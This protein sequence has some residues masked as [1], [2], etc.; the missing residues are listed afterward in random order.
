MELPRLSE[1]RGGGLSGPRRG[2]SLALARSSVPLS[3]EVSFPSRS[4]W[5]GHWRW[6]VNTSS[7]SLIH[8]LTTPLRSL[9]GW[10]LSTTGSTGPSPT[11]SRSG[12][13]RPSRTTRCSWTSGTSKT[14]ARA[15]ACPGPMPGCPAP[16]TPR[17]V[18]E[19][20][21]SPSST[22][23]CRRHTRIFRSS[24]TRVRFQATGSMTTAM[25]MSTTLT[26]GI[27][28]MGDFNPNPDLSKPSHGTAVAGVTGAT[29]NNALGVTGACQNCQILSARIFDGNG[30]IAPDSAVAEAINYAGNMADVLNNS[31]GGGSPSTAIT[32]AIQGANSGGRGGLGSP[33][34]CSNANS[35]SGYRSYTLLGVPAGT[36]TFTWTYHKRWLDRFRIRY[37]MVG[38]HHLPGRS[39]PGFRDMYLAARWLEFFGRCQ[40]DGRQRRS[41]R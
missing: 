31:W 32:T 21:S 22:T 26:A 7:S 38:R 19:P 33:V 28:A 6:L 34:F 9:I 5:S 23:A 41:A 3:W 37:R 2:S 15:G 29:G 40:L 36:W 30:Y 12:G 27:F 24:S 39:H 18:T 4:A 16:G 8:S 14:R 20:R 13:R 1:S 10:R 11:S 35:A 25:A 17:L